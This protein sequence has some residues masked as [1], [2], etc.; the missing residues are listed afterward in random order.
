MFS[1][2]PTITCVKIR[3][4]DK[5]IVKV[6]DGESEIHSFFFGGGGVRA[7]KAPFSGKQL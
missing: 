5:R 3:K 6:K 7:R 1:S 2:F 4:G